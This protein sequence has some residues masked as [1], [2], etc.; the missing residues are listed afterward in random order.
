[1]IFYLIYEI[2]P[3]ILPYDNL[4]DILHALPSQTVT[5]FL[6]GTKNS[7]ISFQ[8]L[9]TIFW[10]AKTS[11]KLTSLTTWLAVNPTL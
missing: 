11:T 2:L 4:P 7:A 6:N 8:T 9:W 3:D 10:L 1:M 5:F